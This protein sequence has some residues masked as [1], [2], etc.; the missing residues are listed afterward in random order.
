MDGYL[1]FYL[2]TL[3]DRRN[4]LP[5]PQLEISLLLSL[6]QNHIEE[7]F[8]FP[9]LASQLPCRFGGVHALTPAPVNIGVASSPQ[10]HSLSTDG[11]LTSTSLTSWL[12]RSQPPLPL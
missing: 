9:S 11:Y 5:A 7:G 4:V 2:A 10:T 1:V 8:T 12:E 3:Y 6:S